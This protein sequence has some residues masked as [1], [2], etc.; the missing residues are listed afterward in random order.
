MMKMFTLVCNYLL[1][2]F[3][4]GFSLLQS[5]AS[6]TAKQIPIRWTAPEALEHLEYYTSTDV[7]GYGVMIW[8]I[9]SGGKLPYAGYSNAQCRLEVVQNGRRLDCPS[10][11]PTELFAVLE[12]CWMHEKDVCAS[13]YIFE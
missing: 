12:S 7:W 2:I 13:F 9:L 10:D 5:I 11:C 6:T 1:Q 3:V 4:G 8:E